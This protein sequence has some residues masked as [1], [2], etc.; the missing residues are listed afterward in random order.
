MDKKQQ[1]KQKALR[2]KALL[3][4]AKAANRDLTA[5]ER[6]EFDALQR[7]I[8]ALDAEIA[9][10]DEQQRS[11]G[12]GTPAPQPGTTPPPAPP[13]GGRMKRSGP[14]RRSGLALQKSPPCAGTSASRTPN[15][16]ATLRKAPGRTRSGPPS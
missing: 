9:Q 4:A 15:S 11:L 8:E 6:A 10:E 2:Q 14:L 13:A 3:D 1:R 7:D 12:G 16:A 5:E